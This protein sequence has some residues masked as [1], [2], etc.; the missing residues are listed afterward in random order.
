MGVNIKLTLVF[1]LLFSGILFLFVRFNRITNEVPEKKDVVHFLPD[2]DVIGKFTWIRLKEVANTLLPVFSPLDSKTVNLVHTTLIEAGLHSDTLYLSGNSDTYNFSLVG[3]VSNY[4]SALKYLNDLAFF[5]D[6][7]TKDSLG[8]RT[9]ELL[10]I[11]VEI[12]LFKEAYLA[13]WRFSES[14]TNMIKEPLENRWSELL[15]NQLLVEHDGLV[16]YGVTTVVLDLLKNGL[17]VEANLTEEFPFEASTY[18]FEADMASCTN[19]QLA[20]KKKAPI[21]KGW[22]LFFSELAQKS[23]LPIIP[24]YENWNGMLSFAFYDAKILTETTKSIVFNDDFEEVLIEKQVKKE[25]NDLAFEIGS[26]NPKFLLEFLESKGILSK[27]KGDYYFLFSPPLELEI[28]Q[29]KLRFQ[30]KGS[31]NFNSDQENSANRVSWVYA[32]KRFIGI[33]N[34][35]PT[36]IRLDVDW[37]DESPC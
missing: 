12:V 20:L 11:P 7:K 3:K 14:N 16:S 28:K 34:F 25:V 26:E 17:S 27:V 32:A 24:F 22:K 21:P 29:N 9:Y 15:P 2:G 13:S 10:E 36:R 8:F 31:R 6:W 30:T 33:M 5:G 23:S 18:H 4:D 19:A 1:F 35:D 37:M